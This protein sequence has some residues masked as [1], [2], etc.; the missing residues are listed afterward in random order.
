MTLNFRDD[1]SPQ[2]NKSILSRLL[3]LAPYERNRIFLYALGLVILAV[4]VL[5]W[6][7]VLPGRTPELPATFIREQVI[8]EFWDV[9]DN[10]N[11]YKPIIAKYRLKHPNV[12]IVYK[13]K[14]V[15]SYRQEVTEAFA[16]G[17]GPD[18]Y[19]IHNTW[20]LLEKNRIRP[21]NEVLEAGVSLAPLVAQYPDA[22]RFDFVREDKMGD[23][24]VYALPLAM[25]TL[26]LYYN[27]NFFNS[28]NILDAP[29]TWE[30]F[31]EDVKKLRR[32]GPDDEVLLAGAVMG[33][34][35]N[36]NRSTD[37]LSLLMLQMG[38]PMNNV[39]LN[40]VTFADA[41]RKDDT[42]PSF[43]DPPYRPGQE[44]LDFY[45][46]F[47]DPLSENYT[48]DAG[49]SYSIDAFVQGDAVMMINYSF[50]R[51][52]IRRKAPFLDFTIAP[53]PQPADRFDK[54][55][56]ANYWG[57]TVAK[58][59]KHADVAW[60]FITFMA[61]EENV[62]LYLE[63]SGRPPALRALVPKYQED[64]E[65]A[66]YANQILS[67]KT[68]VQGDTPQVEDTLA[69]LIEGVLARRKP[70]AQL[71]QEAQNKINFRLSELAD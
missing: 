33:G 58:L 22:V 19:A 56:Y 40:R 43:F 15:D 67:A 49:G 55:N 6:F 34:G 42:P 36:I 14:E 68:W 28:E 62:Q 51:E 64:P 1:F 17:G 30:E 48:W 26:A 3:E 13:K 53:I 69:E 46:S 39:Y 11:V 60:E 31:V 21:L 23:P 45:T 50:H 16:E 18:I 52:T 5:I 20:F 27:K 70:V 71:M 25:D 59:S 29:V 38:T 7:R 35:T 4:V 8:L 44:A 37:I 54:V 61:A 2:H 66:V 63:K 24:I 12:S 10:E 57:L 32:L 9:F 65:L 47:A 41:V